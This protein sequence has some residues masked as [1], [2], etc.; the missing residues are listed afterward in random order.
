MNL[1]KRD[2][3]FTRL[4]F[5]IEL[6]KQ[7]NQ[8]KVYIVG[9]SMG[10]IVCHFFLKWAESPLGGNGGPNWVN[11]HIQGQLYASHSRR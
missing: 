2:M 3:Y 9:H 7:S 6:F 5:Q 11:D 10:S 4:K 8:E 1:E